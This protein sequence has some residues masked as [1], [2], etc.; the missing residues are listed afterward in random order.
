RAGEFAL[1]LQRLAPHKRLTLQTRLE[2]CAL[3]LPADMFADL[4]LLLPTGKTVAGALSSR[5]WDTYTR[6]DFYAELD[7]LG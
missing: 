5:S 3:I 4:T 1:A 6:S 2:G 7:P